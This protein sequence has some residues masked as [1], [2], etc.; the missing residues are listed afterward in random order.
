MPTPGERR[1]QARVVATA[2]PRHVSSRCFGALE[3]PEERIF[4]FT[5]ELAGYP[6]R[7]AFAL[8][9]LEHTA[10]FLCLQSAED[11]AVALAAVDPARIV[12]DWVA[13][14]AEA[15]R[16]LGSA[17]SDLLFVALVAVA[18]DVAQTTVDLLAPIAID[19][20][21]GVGRQIVLGHGDAAQSLFPSRRTG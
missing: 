12:P 11:P 8:L 14:V 21:R 16:V 4:E 7:K 2:G 6:G 5:E 9:E 3:V 17:P 20:R 1:S 18:E 10:P 13:P 15:A 19:R